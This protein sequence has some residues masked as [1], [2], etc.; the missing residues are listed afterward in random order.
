MMRVIVFVLGLLIPFALSPPARAQD[1][2]A[3]EAV[4]ASQLAAFNA[5]DVDQA[6]TYASPTIQG[7]FGNAGNFGMMVQQGYPMVWTNGGAEFLDLREEGGQFRQ[8]ILLRDAGGGR[9]V[10]DYAM[11]ET[12]N[13]WKINGVSIVPQPDV[14]V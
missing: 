7:M 14:G 6:W 4:I 11:I 8:T 10:L 5:R 13:G 2:Q 9:W 3:I 12:A 1:S